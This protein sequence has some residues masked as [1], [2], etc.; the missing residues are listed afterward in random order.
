MLAGTCAALAAALFAARPSMAQ[1]VAPRQTLDVTAYSIDAE[2][3]PRAH[4]LT[5]TAQVTFTAL[6][7]LPSAIFNLHG[8]LRRGSYWSHTCPA[9]GG[10]I[11]YDPPS[12]RA[13][14][15]SS[16]PRADI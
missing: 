7:D 5:A 1:N 4:T 2:I 16:K 15:P 10:G 6:E 8:A 12:K 9:L 13:A 11:G 14:E 3:Q